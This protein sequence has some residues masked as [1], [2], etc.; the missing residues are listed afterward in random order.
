MLKLIVMLF[1]GICLFG[2]DVELALEK[3]NKSAWENILKMHKN[4]DA[5]KY[6]Y[7]V[8]IFEDSAI[9]A[10]EI[11]IDKDDGITRFRY[12]HDFAVQGNYTDLRKAIRFRKALD[13]AI[14]GPIDEPI[15]KFMSQA[16]ISYPN[17][18]TSITRWV[19]VARIMNYLEFED[20][21]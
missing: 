19:S 3:E 9:V 6:K 10:H 5:K 18:E 17:G 11:Y 7:Y 15:E 12:V 21:K 13:D 4:F 8:T 14:M 20:P 1:W 16:L 2:S